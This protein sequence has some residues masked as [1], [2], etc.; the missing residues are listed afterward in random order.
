MSQ[1][2]TFPFKFRVAGASSDAPIFTAQPP[3][4]DGYF[5]A[6][7][8]SEADGEH[9]AEYTQRTV[10]RYIAHGTWVKVAE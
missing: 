5:V 8:W 3:H 1:P 6:V 4:D 9:S 2:T 10:E 7:T